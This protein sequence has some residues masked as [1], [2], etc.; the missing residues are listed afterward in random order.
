MKY[1][2]AQLL[3]P[4]DLG[5]SG[6]KVID[7]DVSKPI[8]R[9]EFRFKTT[10]SANGMSAPGPANITKIELVDGSKPLHSLT[11][12]ENQALAY[13][14][15]P[16]TQMEHGQYIS[17]SSQCDLYAIDFGRFLWD[18]ALAFVPSMF[19][20]P[21]LKITFDED[22]SDT[23]VTVN[24]AEVVAHIFD[25]K[26]ISPMGF[27]SAIEHFSYTCGANNSYETIELPE[28]RPFRQILVRAYQDGYEPWYNIDEARLD[29]GTLDRIPFD[30]TNLEV[31]C[32][33]MKAVWPMI[34]STLVGIAAS[35]GRTFYVPVTDY[36]ANILATNHNNGADLY[37][38][39]ASM[40]GGKAS[41]VSASNSQ[42]GGLATGW[43][44]WHTYQFPMGRQLEIEDWYN[45]AGKKP[46]LRLR[47]S[48]GATSATGQVVLEE[49]YRY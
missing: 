5:A 38:G 28:D 46:R 6:T 32:R 43:L 49:L 16:H 27:L 42:F 3:S 11:G 22:V 48:T 2:I 26:E 21:Q 14:N 29:E 15:R 35:G 34:Q 17:G 40:R 12:Y 20:N 4:A 1:R 24:E 39:A 36:W 47:A 10:K 31:Y 23:G 45:P 9:I 13:Y 30:Y 25:E 41:L 8:S 33:M 18:E 44:P 37:I 7:V 19:V